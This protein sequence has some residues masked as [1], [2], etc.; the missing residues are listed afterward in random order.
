QSSRPRAGA[1]PRTTDDWG[2]AATG[3]RRAARTRRRNRSS[4][5]APQ[6]SVPPRMGS[7]A[8]RASAGRGPRPAT[9]RPAPLRKARR[10]CPVPLLLAARLRHARQD[11]LQGNAVLP[12]DAGGILVLRREYRRPAL[13]PAELALHRAPRRLGG[14]RLT[15]ELV[16]F[17]QV[18]ANAEGVR[19]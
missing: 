5:P 2:A 19:L 6:S 10:A 17:G 15:L 16:P 18:P 9:I 11:T 13:E 1:T 7:P 14:G 3:A 12:G 8:R 4:V